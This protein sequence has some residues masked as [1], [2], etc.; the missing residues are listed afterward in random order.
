MQLTDRDKLIKDIF[1]IAAPYIDNLS[2]AFSFGL[3]N[4]WRRKL[5]ALSGIR[6]GNRVLDVCTGTGETALL[7]T[8]K[9]GEPGLV[10]GID[11]CEDMIEIAK[12][13]VDFRPEN[14]SFVLGD[15]K[16]LS[17]PDNTFDAVTVAFGMRNITDTLPALKEI[18]RVL[19]FGG[20]LFC[21]ELT[22]PEKR[23]FLAMY[24]FYIYNIMPFV[25][26]I[27]VKSEIP[28][29]YLPASIFAFYPREEFKRI[30]EECG[31]IIVNIHSMTLGAATIYGAVK[32]G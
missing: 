29:S 21:L 26:K 28:Y 16:E 17:F 23:W 31:F 24:K 4:L 6:E 8:G 9:V 32:N 15:A 1:S 22:K 13:K 5:I 27:I 25:G 2:A 10:T 19:K 30:I 14:I 18:K 11:F 7:L 3:S 12:K 20:K